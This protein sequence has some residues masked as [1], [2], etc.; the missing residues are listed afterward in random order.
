MFERINDKRKNRKHRRS[1]LLIALLLVCGIAAGCGSGA[2][3]SPAG[4]AGI[5]QTE[6]QDSAQTGGTGFSQTG[7]ADSAEAGGA[8]LSQ[9][10]A[11]NHAL[12]DSGAE[13]D[14]GAADTGME[15]DSA[16]EAAQE[17]TSG[18]IRIIDYL[19]R[20]RRLVEERYEAAD[21]TYTTCESG[22]AVVRNEYDQAGN[23]TRSAYYDLQDHPMLVDELGYAA[24]EYT[25]DEDGNKTSEKYYDV[26]DNM[27]IIDKGYAGVQY[28]YEEGNQII[29]ERYMDADGNPITLENGVASVL[30]KFENE[31]MTVTESW[32]DAEGKTFVFKGD[33]YAYARIRRIY[34][35]MDH[36]IEMQY[37]DEDGEITAGPSGFAIQTYEYDEM[38]RQIGTAWFDED[39]NAFTDSKGCSAMISAYDADG[40][41][42]DTYL[43]D[44]GNE[45][46]VD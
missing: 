40:T 42:T 31:G 3:T 41:R 36:M 4:N 11:M 13:Q 30:K 44:K 27:V 20:E 25:Y 34:A 38:G 8:D 33:D 19:D 6:S 15:A 26:D 46:E 7:N 28:T 18:Y 12:D 16:L 5:S 37:C 35:D 43:D 21:G 22:Y 32:E 45:V 1:T 29:R 10:G 17:S 39:K 23:M 9:P 14:S 24:V 2:R